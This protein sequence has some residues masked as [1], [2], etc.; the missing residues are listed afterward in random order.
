MCLHLQAKVVFDS[1][2]KWKKLNIIKHLADADY[3]EPQGGSR[4]DVLETDLKI[5][6]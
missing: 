3:Q 5:S 1:R 6:V 2:A 4:S